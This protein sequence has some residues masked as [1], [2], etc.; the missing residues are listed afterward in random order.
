M[1]RQQLID[2]FGNQTVIAGRLVNLTDPNFKPEALGRLKLRLYHVQYS[3]TNNA[4]MDEDEKLSYNI[5]FVRVPDSKKSSYGTPVAKATWYPAGS[6][7]QLAY[8]ETARDD[9]Y[10]FSATEY[11]DVCL[12]FNPGLPS[13]GISGGSPIFG[14]EVD[15][16]P[17]ICVPFQESTTPTTATQP[18]APPPTDVTTPQAPGGMI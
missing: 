18:G 14:G 1:T 15:I 16:V 8:Q 4:A 2:L 6:V 9:L 13:G 7:P 3:I 12:T 11:S 5:N 10:K 17:Q